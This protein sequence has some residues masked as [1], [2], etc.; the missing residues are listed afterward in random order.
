MQKFKPIRKTVVVR[1]G[2]CNFAV[3]ENVMVVNKKTGRNTPLTRL[4]FSKPHLTR[5]G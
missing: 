2:N 4:G 3:L 1:S 5:K